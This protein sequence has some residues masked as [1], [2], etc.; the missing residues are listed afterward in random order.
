MTDA[1]RRAVEVAKANGW[2]L[3]MDSVE[4]PIEREELALAL[5]EVPAA[6]ETWDAC[7]PSARKQMLWWVVSAAK[8][9]TRARR[10]ATIVNEAGQGR[11]AQ[12]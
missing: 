10:I 4:D 3:L 2:W 5:D 8:P 9:E 6:R 12:G 7:P 1:G 11:R